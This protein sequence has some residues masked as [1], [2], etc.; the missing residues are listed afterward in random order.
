MAG[1][2]NERALYN[3]HWALEAF[4]KYDGLDSIEDMSRDEI[5]EI[6]QNVLSNAFEEELTEEEL[7]ERTEEFLATNI[8]E[9]FNDSEYFDEKYKG[10]LENDE[11]YLYDTVNELISDVVNSAENNEMQDT[12]ELPNDAPEDVEE[13]ENEF[14]KNPEY[15]LENEDKDYFVQEGRERRKDIKT[16]FRFVVR[17]DA[18]SFQDL[19]VKIAVLAKLE[20]DC[21]DNGTKISEIDKENHIINLCSRYGYNLI[22]YET[23]FI[24]KVLGYLGFTDEMINQVD[25][26]DSKNE[27]TE[28]EAKAV[29]H[30]NIEYYDWDGKAEE[31]E[32][33]RE[34]NQRAEEERE[35]QDLENRIKA[36]EMERQEYLEKVNE[37]LQQM[38]T[39]EENERLRQEEEDRRKIKE[40]NERL[41]REEE[42]RIEREKLLQQQEEEERIRQKN[43]EEARLREQAVYE[44]KVEEVNRQYREMNA[45]KEREER[46]RERIAK[47]R[48]EQR[49]EEERLRRE[50][51]L[52]QKQQEEER[53]RR[54]AEEKRQR[55]L[56]RVDR[57]RRIQAEKEGFKNKDFLSLEVTE[58]E[59]ELAN[60]FY[61]FDFENGD[62]E[63]KKSLYEAIDALYSKVKELPKQKETNETEGILLSDIMSEDE[64]DNQ[65][66]TETV[67]I[68]PVI[69]ETVTQEPVKKEEAEPVIEENEPVIEEN[70]PVKEETTVEKDEPVVEK[71][72]T[73]VKKDEPVV[74]K[75]ETEV[76]KDEPVV[77]KEETEVEKDGPVVEKEET[78][79]KKDEPVVE[80]EE[81]EVKKD[82]PVKEEPVKKEPEKKEP[83]KESVKKEPEKKEPVKEEP[84]KTGG[85]R[86]KKHLQDRMN[87]KRSFMEPVSYNSLK[88]ET[89][90]KKGKDSVAKTTPSVK[91]EKS[92]NEKIIEFGKE[93][94]KYSN[95]KLF[96]NSKEFNEMK[97]AVETAVRLASE[98]KEDDRDLRDAVRL[99]N[100]KAAHYI[101]VKGNRKR[102]TDLGDMRLQLANQA[103]D[104]GH[105]KSSEF[106]K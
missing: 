59:I 95:E 66:E 47:L 65:A 103:K 96:G 62:A 64:F 75:E 42:E 99:V 80:K 19:A 48:E 90:P 39:D 91:R 1:F 35:R 94:G 105:E 18:K 57:L 31:R 20:K 33:E 51:E 77:E 50:E 8:D 100:D 56:N 55:S 45:R 58:Y 26:N 17:E 40:E 13:L 76:K 72:E 4:R 2:D 24:D 89:K 88:E 98:K 101:A 106:T 87:K 25:A 52:R 69:E 28:E 84:A 32:Y 34:L 68:E 5:I 12:N 3:V 38:E 83:A 27:F 53:K 30:D 82:E 74:E 46:E 67:K 70:E 93:F 97:E 21:A 49:L 60:K 14:M 102:I 79:V 73:E 10:I 15:Q 22:P 44:K 85:S 6:T 37:T 36:E 54:E 29:F 23:G 78:E 104:L 81:T 9:L 11:E 61:E 92:L 86:I 16:P 71:E 7:K 41:Q 43:L 63:E